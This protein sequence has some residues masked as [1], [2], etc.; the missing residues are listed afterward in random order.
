M[1]QLGCNASAAAHAGS[2]NCAKQLGCTSWGAMH[3]LQLTLEVAHQALNLRL[4]EPLVVAP[5]PAGLGTGSAA[6]SQLGSRHEQAKPVVLP[7]AVLGCA[8]VHSGSAQAA[9]P[10]FHSPHSTH[11]AS[12][13]TRTASA[14]LPW[15][16]DSTRRVS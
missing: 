2:D 3:Q 1:H 14:S 13:I 5:L 4:A 15:N 11:H 7:E 8:C 10:P 12:S 6:I 9:L 16:I